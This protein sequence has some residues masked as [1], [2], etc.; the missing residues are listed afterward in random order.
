MFNPNCSDATSYDF[1]KI[2]VK[3]TAISVIGG[4]PEIGEMLADSVIHNV[5]KNENL[6]N[7]PAFVLN[8]ELFS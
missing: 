7:D 5:L 2:P 4:V 3:K 1:K 8:W 6:S